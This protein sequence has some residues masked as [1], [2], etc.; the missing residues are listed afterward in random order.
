MM[1]LPRGPMDGLWARLLD[2]AAAHPEGWTLV[3]AQMVALHA[4]ER[5]K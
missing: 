2:L 5:G 3:G 1:D 4:Y